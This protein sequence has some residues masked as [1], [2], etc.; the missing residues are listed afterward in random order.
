MKE[1]FLIEDNMVSNYM[2][3]TMS[4]LSDSSMLLPLKF[5][6]DVSATSSLPPTFNFDSVFFI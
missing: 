4:F 6:K 5:I 1:V 3:V 2:F